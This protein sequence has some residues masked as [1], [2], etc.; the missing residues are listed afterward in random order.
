VG[1]DRSVVTPSSVTAH[2]PT[3]EARLRAYDRTARR[4]LG[5]ATGAGFLA[6]GAAI[7][8]GIAFSLAVAAVVRGAT[9]LAGSV[10][11]LGLLVVLAVGRAALLFA[12]ELLAQRASSRLTGRLRHDLLKHLGVLGPA[13]VSRERTGELSAVLGDGLEAVDA[14]VTEFQP[15]RA[16]AVAVPLLVLAVVFVLDPPT[17]LVLLATGPLLMLLLTFIGARTRV[18]SQRRFAEL[19]WMSAYFVEMLRGIATLK[20]F[21]RSREQVD[22]MRVISDRYAD[23]TMSLLRTAF[24]TSLVLDW[25]AAVA[26]ALVAVEVGLRLIEGAIP[27][28]RAL[29]VLVVAPEFFLPLRQLAQRYHAGSAGRAAGERIFA[30]LD[31]HAPADTAVRVDRRPARRAVPGPPTIEFD[32]VAFT[33][34]DRAHPAIDG[35]TLRIDAGERVAL[36]GESGAGKSTLLSLLLRFGEP[37]RGRI[38]VDGSPLEDLDVAGWRAGVAWVPQRA[39]LFYGSV[40]DNI[41]M[42]RP[43]ATDADIVEAARGAAAAGFIEALPNGFETPIGEGGVRLSGGQRQRVAIARALLRDA[44]LVLLDEPTAHLDLE[45]EDAVADGFERLTDG[46]TVIVVAHRLRLARGAHRVV[47]LDRGRVVEAGDPDDLRRHV[48]PY[49]RLERAQLAATGPVA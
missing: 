47:V 41:R 7:A 44:P 33:F 38:L 16:L 21:G 15:A 27:F 39:H 4:L 8:A 11:L 37:D 46:R 34:P 29:A 5:V 14:Y 13:Y 31:T 24:Q 48:G 49:A 32:D 30:V 20:M 35:L 43:G 22:T 12:Q 6:G 28:E 17:T 25:G 1:A 10:P 23:S 19:R 3:A 9:G 45:G 2:T 42:A 40:A 36:V 26:M 18:Q